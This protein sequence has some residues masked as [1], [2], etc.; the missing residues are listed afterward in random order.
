LRQQLGIAW[1]RR[2]PA[3]FAHGSLILNSTAKLFRHASADRHA[4]R[5]RQVASPEP[6][7]KAKWRITGPRPVSFVIVRTTGL[8]EQV[9]VFAWSTEAG[10]GGQI[11]FWQGSHYNPFNC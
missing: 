8:S 3:G 10:V 9:E 11:A 1:Q 6:S 4:E 5:Y 7:F 2:L